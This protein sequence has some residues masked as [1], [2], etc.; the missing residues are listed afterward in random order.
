MGRI[1]AGWYA[2]DDT[3][4]FAQIVQKGT[5]RGG[6]RDDWVFSQG[7][8]GIYYRENLGDGVF[9]DKTHIPTLGGTCRQPETGGIRWGDVVSSP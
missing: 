7:E 9:G 2:G 1:H 8:S 4:W 5:D 6:E 3:V